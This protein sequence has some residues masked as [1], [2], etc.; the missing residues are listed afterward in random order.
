MGWGV[1]LQREGWGAGQREGRIITGRIVHLVHLVRQKTALGGSP[2]MLRGLPSHTRPA[3]A[4]PC[5]RCPAA[6][7]CTSI[8]QHPT[9]LKYGPPL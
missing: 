9:P 8:K 7:A 2:A 4:T 3:K 6:H 5:P 1:S